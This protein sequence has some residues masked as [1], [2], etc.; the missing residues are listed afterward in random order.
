MNEED[1]KNF[2]KTSGYMSLRKRMLTSC[3][4]KEF[5]QLIESKVQ[6]N[7]DGKGTDELQFVDNFLKVLEEEIPG[8]IW[9]NDLIVFYL[10]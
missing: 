8:V 10:V 4:M 7:P 1:G 6:A 5:L 9:L 2:L 3:S